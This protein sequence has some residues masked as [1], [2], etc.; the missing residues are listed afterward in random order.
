MNGIQQKTRESGEVN[1]II[2]HVSKNKYPI[3]A[4]AAKHTIDV[5]VEVSPNSQCGC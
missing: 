4:Q 1:V 2:F 5:S 3:S